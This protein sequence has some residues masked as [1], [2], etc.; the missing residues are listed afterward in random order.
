MSA[1]RYW[2]VSGS[3]LDNFNC[4]VGASGVALVNEFRYLNAN[5][6]VTG[7]IKSTVVWSSLSTLLFCRHVMLACPTSPSVMKLMPSL[8]TDIVTVSPMED[9]SRQMRANSADGILTVALCSVSGM[10]RCSE[11][12]SM[13]F[14]SKSDTRSWSGI[15]K[16]VWVIT[17]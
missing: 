8:L 3:C 11:S 2:T 12:M 9:R 1:M 17:Q 16:K 10:P 14:S 13:S 5:V 6:S 4:T 15:R 7:S